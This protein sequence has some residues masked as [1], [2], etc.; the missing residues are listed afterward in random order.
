MDLEGRAVPLAEMEKL[1]RAA[2]AHAG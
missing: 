2:V 1:L